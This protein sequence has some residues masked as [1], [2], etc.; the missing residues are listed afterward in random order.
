MR[1]P[2]T[3]AWTRRDALRIA[4]RMNAAV[5]RTP[6]ANPERVYCVEPGLLPRIVKYTEGLQEVTRRA[7]S[8]HGTAKAKR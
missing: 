7:A 6:G 8:S 1:V 3:R 5:R 4:A 2:V